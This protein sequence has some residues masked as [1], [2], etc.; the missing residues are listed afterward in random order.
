MEESVCSFSSTSGVLNEEQSLLL[1][2][3]MVWL[4]LVGPY[5]YGEM[6]ASVPVWTY[7]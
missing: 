4:T 5:G 2:I 3:K 1:V 7:V 6:C